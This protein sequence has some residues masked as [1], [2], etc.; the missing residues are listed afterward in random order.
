MNVAINLLLHANINLN[1]CTD[2]QSAN[3]VETENWK[4]KIIKW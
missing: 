4:L 1:I 3:V 2:L